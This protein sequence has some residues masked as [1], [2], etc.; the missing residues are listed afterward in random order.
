MFSL[1]SGQGGPAPLLAVVA[2]GSFLLSGC[3][4]AGA[5][6]GAPGGSHAAAPSTSPASQPAPSS[7]PAADLQ[8]PP[9]PAGVDAETREGLE[10]F[11]RYWFAL[12]SYGYESNNWSGLQAV[13]DR[14]C[15]TCTNVIGEVGKHYETGGWIQG[16][17][18]IVHAVS[19][20]LQPGARGPVSST[21]TL[22]QAELVYFDQSG[23]EAAVSDALP[24]TRSVTIAVHKN[25]RW[26]MLD[27]GTPSSS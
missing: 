12:F 14:G 11:T 16:G 26:V 20:T 13:T 6:S 18:V 25:N 3:Q 24:L 21:V 8:P 7:G 9:K 27:F 10:A 15:D 23:R 1:R 22:E 19:T 4:G 5:G 17:K 2:A